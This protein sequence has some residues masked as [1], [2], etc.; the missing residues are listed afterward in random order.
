MSETEV[1][2]TP[3]SLAELQGLPA[4]RLLVMLGGA[5]ALVFGLLVFVFEA[6]EGR[7]FAGT[8]RFGTGGV[9][10]SFVLCLMFGLLLVH[11]MA[12]MARK[13]AEGAVLAFAFSMVLLMFGGVG[14]MIGGLLGVVG[15]AFALIR[16]VKLT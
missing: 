1:Y 6:V 5:S 7:A 11:A 16:H 10:L 9:V 13:P 15:G 2:E 14:G 12:L 3:R 4:D 8:A